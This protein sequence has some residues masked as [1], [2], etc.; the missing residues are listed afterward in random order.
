MLEQQASKKEGYRMGTKKRVIV[1]KV[2]REPIEFNPF[3]CGLSLR[4]I[5][6]RSQ[7]DIAYLS[8]VKNG[9]IA[10]TEE[11]LDRVLAVVQEVRV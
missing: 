11:N 8:R 7:L 9:Q 5:S 4:E 1:K 10:I 2:V 3:E 6:R